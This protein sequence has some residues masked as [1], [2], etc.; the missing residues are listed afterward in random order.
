MP[1]F[2]HLSCITS[3]V[4]RETVTHMS[5]A[6][7]FRYVLITI[8]GTE[9]LQGQEAHYLWNPII[10]KGSELEDRHLGHSSVLRC[11]STNQLPIH[12][13]LNDAGRLISGISRAE[14][15]MWFGWFLA[16]YESPERVS[17]FLWW[18]ETGRRS[19]CQKS[20]LTKK[21][22]TDFKHE[23]NKFPGLL[24][25]SLGQKVLSCLH[26]RGHSILRLSQRRKRKNGQDAENAGNHFSSKVSDHRA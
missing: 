21:L 19:F 1:A 20:M 7:M 16:L 14:L 12:Y 13:L 10:K 23:K 4:Q 5:Q 24:P 26:A 2:I 11:Y 9:E 17:H 25:M 3:L 8:D 6:E 22:A 18:P 15:D